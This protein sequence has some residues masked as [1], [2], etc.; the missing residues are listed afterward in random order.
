MVAAKS[1]KSKAKGT[2]GRAK[3]SGSTGRTRRA[4]ANKKAPSNAFLWREGG[5]LAVL[6][7]ALIALLSLV[8]HDPITGDNWIGLVGRW[9]A[10]SLYFLVGLGAY[11]VVLALVAVGLRLLVPEHVHVRA[12]VWVGAS[13]AVISLL[14]FFQ[15]V[16]PAGIQPWGAPVGGLLAEGL[17]DL[18]VGVI[19]TVG[20][21]VVL[22]VGFVVGMTIVTRASLVAVTTRVVQGVRSTT[23]KLSPLARLG[24]ILTALGVAF[25]AVGAKAAGVFRRKP[26]N[27]EGDDELWDEDG[28]W[29]DSDEAWDEDDADAPIGV[30]VVSSVLRR[31]H[32]DVVP[33][34][35]QEPVSALHAANAFDPSPA[36]S[37]VR[38]EPVSVS[39]PPSNTPSNLQSSASSNP[40]SGHMQILDDR[41]AF[42]EPVHSTLPLKTDLVREA[43]AN[44]PADPAQ[45]AIENA[46]RVLEERK[47]GAASGA[48][49]S[50][51]QDFTN[52][53]S[54]RP[55]DRDRVRERM[56]HPIA[57][58]MVTTT[59]SNAPL[60]L[61]PIRVDG[62]ADAAPARPFAPF[63]ASSA[64]AV[65]PGVSPS[66]SPAASPAVSPAAAIAAPASPAIHEASSL[67]ARASGADAFDP[68][69]VGV[70]SSFA[71]ASWGAPAESASPLRADS[72]PLNL[73]VDSDAFAA[74]KA[75]ASP[76]AAASGSH[77]IAPIVSRRIEI[78]EDEGLRTRVPVADE[79]DE[80]DDEM[81]DDGDVP[82]V[83]G[84]RAPAGLNDVAVAEDMDDD[85]LSQTAPHR[86]EW[87]SDAPTARGVAPAP[88]ARPVTHFD[89]RDRI[90]R[91]IDPVD[92]IEDDG[93][94]LSD[95]ELDEPTGP[96]IIE[97]DALRN[98]PTSE[99]FEKALRALEAKRERQPWKFP[100]LDFFRYEPSTTVVDEAALRELASQLVEALSDYKVRGRVT[101]ICPG[102][103]VTR[104]EFEPEPGTKLS[105]ISGLSTDIAMRLRADNVRIIAP[106]PGK[107]CVGVEIPNEIR[108]TV[109]L[110][111]ILADEKFTNARSK[112]TM[113]LGKDIEGFPVVADLA[114]MPHLLVAGTTGSGKSVSV[115]AM[116]TSVLCSA[117]PDDV[118]LILIDPK[119]LEFALYEDIPHLLLPVVTDPMKAATALQWAVQEMER[120]Y[121]M[122]KELRVRN[123]EGYNQKMEQLQAEVRR[124]GASSFAQ[125]MLSEE[126]EDGRPRHRHMPF[127]IVVV[128]EFADLMMA[129][130]K[131]VEI[132][133]ARIAQKARA[134][135]IHCILATQRPSVDVLTG[136]IKSNFP[137]RMSFRLISGTDSR[138]V[139][140]TQGAEN[141]LGMGDMLYR[142]PGSSDLVRVHGAFVDEVEIERV[143]EFL[144][145][146]REA[147]Y[148]ESIL[149]GELSS[150]EDDPD[151]RLDTKYEEALDVCIQA[152]F[153]S[154]SMIQR[155]LGI[156][157]NR[158]ANIV[159]EMERRGVVGPSSGGASRREVLIRR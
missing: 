15:I 5:G 33:E 153:A 50:D 61:P 145:E 128:D 52:R 75:P 104:F 159:E 49:S 17:S 14:T 32:L 147:D 67:P 11:G 60:E 149:S 9:T 31:P 22:V 130:G 101:G 129:A 28:E 57:N 105:K 79:V 7:L 88:L 99:S 103:V 156:G 20:A 85:T 116:I 117:S 42:D 78:G 132:A 107:G 10:E 3:A 48:L 102:P 38:E 43:V 113:A 41:P 100:T 140:D 141:L 124:G 18:V 56:N 63:A 55:L 144:K 89:E 97:S 84:Q 40:P 136:T 122:M 93:Y 154:I 12:S 115:N 119:Q 146:Q 69:P 19:G 26:S 76:L 143:V 30:E 39:G 64:P 125:R 106:I 138:T 123:I 108:E 133:V 92:E 87:P 81:I 8:S 73:S 86:I 36:R 158:A 47:R 70:S 46:R 91:A 110:K 51:T 155:R 126:D 82:I 95:D 118:R 54:E 6:A 23:S 71:Q 135:G 114:K 142:P 150:S 157:Y 34:R 53:L 35:A 77:E 72:T 74:P 148:D 1:A 27:A 24:A 65:S 94:E 4:S 83:Y 139:I 44:T 13:A 120:R 25:R 121:G 21:I 68:K 137:T 98:R 151:D 96:Q 127:I 37:I 134:A 90:T 62:N 59:R 80:D 58:P 111:E 152:G 66:A 16:L 109:Y 45:A 2:Q 29:E 131:D 112:L